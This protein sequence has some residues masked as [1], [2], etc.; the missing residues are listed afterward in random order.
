MQGGAKARKLDFL[1]FSWNFKFKY[2]EPCSSYRNHVSDWERLFA[3]A[4]CS[5]SGF[6]KVEEVTYV[7]SATT[8]LRLQQRVKRQLH[9]LPFFVRIKPSDVLIS[10]LNL[11]TTSRALQ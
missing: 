2:L 6:G 8:F 11:P 10:H 7:S 5:M 1:N 3:R 4:N 9:D